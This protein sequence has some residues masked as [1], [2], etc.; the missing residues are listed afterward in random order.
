MKIKPISRISKVKPK[1]S[2]TLASPKE[3]TEECI[4]ELSSQAKLIAAQEAKLDERMKFDCDRGSY[5]S[6]VFESTSD[7]KEYCKKH[8]IKLIADSFIFADDLDN[9]R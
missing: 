3:I 8:G 2:S 4:E 9:L 7:R 6:I 1:N 5:F